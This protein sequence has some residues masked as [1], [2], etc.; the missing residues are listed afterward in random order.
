MSSRLRLILLLSSFVVV[1]FAEIDHRALTRPDEG[2]YSE[3]AREMS[4]SGDFVTPR[5]NDLKYFEKP[6]LQ[7]WATA[8][9]YKVFGEHNWTARLWS[10][11]TGLFGVGC[12]YWIARRMYGL[13]TAIAATAISGSALWYF[14]IAHINTLDMGL[15]AWMTLTLVSF[16]HAQRDDATPRGR[17]IAMHVAWAAMG[18]AMLSKGLIGIVLPG[19]VLVFYSLWQRDWK[20]WDRL[21][22]A[23]GLLLFLAIVVP[24]FAWVQARNPEFSEF[25]F[26]HEHL[27]RFSSTTHRR[28]GAWWY[29][30]PILVGGFAPWTL[31]LAW[32]LPSVLRNLR[33]KEAPSARAAM[34]SNAAVAPAAEKPF[35]G[36]RLLAVWVGFIFLFFSASGSKLPSYIVPVFPALALLLA[37]RMAQCPPRAYAVNVAIG[38]VFAIACIVALA[39]AGRFASDEVASELLQAMWPWLIASLTALLIGLVVA[40]RRRLQGRSINAIVATALGCL[41]AWQLAI[42]GYN[43]LSPASSSYH[44]VRS[45]EAR[46]G[47]LDRTLPMYSIRTYEQTLP[48]YLKR[49]MTLVDFY[50]EMALGLFQEP[51]KGIE[52]LPKFLPIW[53]ALPAGYAA[54]RPETYD[55][56]KQLQVPMR[57]LGSDTR[58]VI[59]SRK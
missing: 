10:A 55:E 13:E 31:L 2:R 38:V 1:W 47:P 3:I 12:V 11:L 30:V 27:D 16:L 52:S 26:F 32:V 4:V 56:L 21:H 48:F 18:L 53:S 28:E 33:A 29:F 5:L 45:I 17:S 59:V 44:L 46:H 19:G 25:F 24:W 58:R 42:R 20:L 51:H 49:T 34:A 35:H 9:A 36:E 50:D 57:L 23:T 54:M 14:A 15:T 37:P 7:Y 22:M 6:P 43:E 39:N 41:V 8:I 40:W